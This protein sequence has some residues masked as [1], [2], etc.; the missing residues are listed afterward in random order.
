MDGLSVRRTI[1]I[2]PARLR[3]FDTELVSLAIPARQMGCDE[4]YSP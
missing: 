4:A 2:Q 3:W 1:A